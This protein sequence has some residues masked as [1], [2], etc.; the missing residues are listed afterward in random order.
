VL[1]EVTE[2][3]ARSLGAGSV[4]EQSQAEGL[5]GRALGKLFA[6]AENYPDLKANQNYQE[7]QKQLETTENQIEMSRRYYNGTARNYNIKVESF[8]SSIIAKKFRFTPA[9]YFELEDDA[10]RA[11]PQVSFDPTAPPSEAPENKE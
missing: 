4:A 2:M 6:V 3:R 7:L 10:V 11:V 8:P 9:Q 1:D 5:L